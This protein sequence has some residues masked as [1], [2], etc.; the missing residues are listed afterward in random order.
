MI[1]KELGKPESLIKFVKD[2]PGSRPDVYAM[3]S[4]KAGDELGW[5]PQF[6]FSEAIRATIAWYQTN[7][8]G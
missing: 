8:D 7:S 3:D 6:I 5:Q 1:L 4:R 2:S